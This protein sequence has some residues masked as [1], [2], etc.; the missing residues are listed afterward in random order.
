MMHLEKSRRLNIHEQK[1][2]SESTIVIGF[3]IIILCICTSTS[4][5]CD[6]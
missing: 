5:T 1:R 4:I 6:L 3:L 2:T